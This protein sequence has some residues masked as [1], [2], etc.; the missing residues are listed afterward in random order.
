MVHDCEMQCNSILHAVETNG[1]DAVVEPVHESAPLAKWV[2]DRLCRI[3]PKTGESCAWYHGFRQYLRALG[4]AITPAHHAGFLRDS[5][6]SFVGQGDRLRVLISG[7]IDY[8]M[9][10]HVLWA[11]RRGGAVADVTVVDVCET[12]LF[13][14]QWYAR[15]IGGRVRTVRAS[16]L[17]FDEPAG[18]DL[19]CTNSFF[20]QF[21]PAQRPPLMARW[22]AL[23]TPHGRVITVTPFRPGHAAEMVGFTRE[24]AGAL[25][26]AVRASA[27]RVNEAFDLE[28]GE[29]ERLADAFTA[30][31][32]VHP[33]RSIH[34]IR[35]L[36]EEAGFTLDHLTSGPISD[37]HA[38]LSGPTVS[39]LAEYAM[40]V[41]RRP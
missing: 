29:L 20:G 26:E 12:P 25:R 40:V 31:M 16:I 37:D 35:R 9:F 21:S 30:R 15:R 24:E 22:H 10:A 3:D 23:L 13:L 33:V 4:L 14:N 6:A 34:E 36:F 1:G 11:C 27:H 28:T 17:E 2:A 32:R 38:Q 7:A 18:F 39:R 8:S 41:A 19:I 5:M